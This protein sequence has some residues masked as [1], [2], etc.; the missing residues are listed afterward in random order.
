MVNASE[1]Q[2][3][4]PGN[5]GSNLDSGLL[6]VEFVVSAGGGATLT[7]QGASVFDGSVH[8]GWIQ[9]VQIVASVAGVRRRFTWQ[10][11]TVRFYKAGQ[12]TQSIVRSS[13]CWPKADTYATPSFG[14]RGVRYI[15][16]SADNDSVVVT[17]Q[18]RLQADAPVVQPWEM[19]GKILVFA[20]NCVAT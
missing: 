20:A 3:S 16:S 1:G 7:V 6:S 12:L 10:S 17:G 13:E 19:Q 2:A 9:Q 11:I 5:P 15:P 4:W 18:V 14:W 8:Y